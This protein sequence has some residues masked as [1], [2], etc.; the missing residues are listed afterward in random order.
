M[1]SHVSEAFMKPRSAT[2]LIAALVLGV[3]GT[4]LGGAGR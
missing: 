1:N 2:V 3:I 4:A